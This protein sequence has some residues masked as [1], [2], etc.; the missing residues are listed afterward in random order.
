MEVKRSFALNLYEILSNAQS[1]F[2]KPVTGKFRYVVSK[3]RKLCEDE[4][5]IT[6]EAFPNDPGFEKFEAERLDILREAGIHSNADVAKLDPEVRI[7]L[8][9]RIIK[10]REEH[11]DACNAQDAIVAERN[12]FCDETISLPLATF[13]VNDIPPIIAENDWAIWEI[14]EKLMVDSEEGV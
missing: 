1:V 10:L 3:N 5:K 9:N 14:L 2:G 6:E 13:S 11:I 7:S 4:A 12:K 8:E